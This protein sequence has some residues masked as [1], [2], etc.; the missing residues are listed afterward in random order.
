MF[1]LLMTLVVT[2]EILSH[3]QR[4]EVK[5]DCPKTFIYKMKKYI[6]L[7]KFLNLNKIQLLLKWVFI[8]NW[9]LSLEI[10]WQQV[11]LMLQNPPQHSSYWFYYCC[12]LDLHFFY[13]FFTRLF[14]IVPCT[15]I[16]MGSTVHAPHFFIF[17]CFLLL[18]FNLIL[19][20]NNRFSFL[21]L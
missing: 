18:S 12:C 19:F 14:R 3:S 1:S 13:I 20:W 16:I 10:K 2:T 11:S 4:D 15:L 8:L 7:V 21:G 6:V 5:T 9:W 17:Y